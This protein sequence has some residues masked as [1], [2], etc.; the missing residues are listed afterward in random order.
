[1]PQPAAQ[2]REERIRR[3]DQLLRDKKQQLVPISMPDYNTA[4]ARLAARR[5][6]GSV[7]TADGYMGLCLEWLQFR[8]GCEAYLPCLVALLQPLQHVHLCADYAATKAG[9]SLPSHGVGAAEPAGHARGR[10]AH[11]GV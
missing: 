5:G 2:Q 8:P 1:M 7:E 9:L 3:Y 10:S 11:L 6:V 4:R